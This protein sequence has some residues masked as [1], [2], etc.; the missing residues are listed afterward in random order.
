MNS[1][2]PVPTS[3]HLARFDLTGRV[4]L[5]TGS[6]QGLGLALARGLAEAGAHVV[7]NGRDEGKLKQAAATLKTDGFSVDVLPFDVTQ[8]SEIKHA[9]QQLS[10]RH[11]AIDILVNN[12]GITRRALLTDLEE[13]AWREVI[14]TNLN[15]AFLVSRAVV[16]GMISNKRGK[17]INICSLMSELSRPMTGAYA[18]AKGGLKM[19]TRAM[20]A[21]WAPHGIQVNAIGPGYFATELTRPLV[22]NPEFNQWIQ[23]RTPAGRWGRPDELVGAAVF[24]ASPASEFVNGQIL[25][26]DGGLSTTI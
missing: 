19:L 6:S 5:V 22:E 16:A 11:G 3:A 25:Y 9:V 4:A 18:A 24:L 13:S 2:F 7:L 23:R 15:S 8:S 20:A 10:E 21:E 1:I 12:A 17:V 14:D 26:V